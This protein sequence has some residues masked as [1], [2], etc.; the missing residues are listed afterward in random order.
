MATVKDL[1]TYEEPRRYSAGLRSY[2]EVI[3]RSARHRAALIAFI[4]LCSAGTLL[5]VTLDLSAPA[6]IAAN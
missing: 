6:S 4:I 2:L 1:A 5:A 3:L